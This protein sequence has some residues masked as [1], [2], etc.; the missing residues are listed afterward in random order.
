MQKYDN[1]NNSQG[2]NYDNNRQG[3]SILESFG[4]QNLES[5]EKFSKQQNLTFMKLILCVVGL[6]TLIAVCLL[7]G[8]HYYLK[9]SKLDS[10]L[11]KNYKIYKNKL[12]NDFSQHAKRL[13][14]NNN[15]KLKEIYIQGKQSYQELLNY[16]LKLQKKYEKKAIDEHKENLTLQ[17][18]VKEL[19][20]SLTKAEVNIV[21]LEA[22]V[23]KIKSNNKKLQQTNK[24]Y[25][26]E[27]LRLKK[28]LAERLSPKELELLKQDINNDE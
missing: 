9:P 28:R 18:R 23:K 19:V 5:L 11:E 2:L 7:I 1:I 4:K 24:K 13:E 16:F 3:L 15:S 8:M 27:I 26:L 21:K 14:H 17:K 25:K 6:F 22:L 20:I 10:S 12:L